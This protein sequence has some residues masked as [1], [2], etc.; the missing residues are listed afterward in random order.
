MTSKKRKDNCEKEETSETNRTIEGWD[1]VP[2][3][4]ARQAYAGGK[5]VTPRLGKIF[6]RR[7]REAR[8]NKEPLA[9]AGSTICG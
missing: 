3:M 9:V 2:Q 1:W 7:K 8:I 6:L 4:G 5:L